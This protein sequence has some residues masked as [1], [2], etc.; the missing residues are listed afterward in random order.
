MRWPATRR[1]GRTLDTEPRQRSWIQLSPRTLLASTGASSRGSIPSDT[2]PPIMRSPR[3]ANFQ[4]DLR[5]YRPHIPQLLDAILTGDCL[6]FCPIRKDAFLRDF[7]SETDQHC[8]PALVS[9]LLALATLLAPEKMAA[10]AASSPGGSSPEGLGYAFAQDAVASLYNGERLPR[11]I[12]DIQ[13][14]GILALY[15]FCGGEMKDG[16]GFAG[17]YGIAIATRWER[18]DDEATFPDRETCA[19]I[20]CAALSFNRLFFLIEDYQKTLDEL[21]IEV[22][23]DRPVLH[24]ANSAV[25]KTNL[26]GSMTDDIFFMRD[27]SLSPDDPKVLAAKLFEFA[28]WVYEAR[29]NPDKTMEQAIEVYQ[30]GLHWYDTLFE[31]TRKCS[32]Q[33]PF[34]LFTHAYYQFGVMCLL[35]P[36]VLESI[37][38]TSD[39]TL[40]MAACRQAA[41]DIEQLVQHYGNLYNEA[42]LFDFMPFFKTAMFRFLEICNASK[43]E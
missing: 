34:T 7:E 40:P 9:T 31:Y 38:I 28:E 19:Y 11:R 4:A 41:G 25:L 42:N 39:G 30:N 8:S 12:A 23:I 16:L 24:D 22:G 36:Y 35:T 32:S 2:T 3:E 6:S 37:P 18:K 27:F 5:H 14:I 26:S 43:C 17:D 1:S 10:L 20:Y 13:A 33:T 15:S 21:A 29:C